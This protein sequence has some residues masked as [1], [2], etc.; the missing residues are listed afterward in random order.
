MQKISDRLIRVAELVPKGSRLADVGTDHGYVPIW[1]LERGDIPSAIAMDVN[2]G[3]L[4][5]ARENRDK[6][7]YQEVMELRLS[8]GLEK[9]RPGEADTVLIAGMG[10][11]LMIQI[12][13]EGRENS[14]GVSTW[15]LQPQS[16]IPSVRRY[17]MTHGFNIVDE[18][19]LMDE[20]KYYMAM[21]ALPGKAEPW[22]DVEYLFGKHL[23]ERR[24]PVLKAFLEKE[25]RIYLK[26]LNQLTENHQ[27]GTVRRNEVA[28]YLAALDR[29]MEYYKD[30]IL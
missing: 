1:L 3:P 12:L 17:L 14:R 23:L 4:L 10:G 6:Y 21:K 13:E 19:M 24:H 15:V 25:K 20:G 18:I 5:R 22:D 9:L 26:I 11:P 16:E 30:R 28:A 7:G 2:R 8:N 27:S 29:A